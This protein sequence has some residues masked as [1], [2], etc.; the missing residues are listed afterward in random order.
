MNNEHTIEKLQVEFQKESEKNYT[1]Y[2][3][4]SKERE[5]IGTVR[6]DL[7]DK[8]LRMKTFTKK[9]ELLLQNDYRFNID[10]DAFDKLANCGFELLQK[11]SEHQHHLL[12]EIEQSLDLLEIRVEMWKDD[13]IAKLQAI[14]DYY[15]RIPKTFLHSLKVEPSVDAKYEH[16]KQ[17]LR[18]KIEKDEK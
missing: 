1:L 12:M 9:V 6:N 8:E 16:I 2:E 3:T 7:I 18:T 17:L 11:F 14:L 15:V 5:L 10:L 4:L 13:T